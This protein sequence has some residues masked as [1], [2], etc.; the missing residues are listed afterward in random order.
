MEDASAEGPT[1]KYLVNLFLP[2]RLA[3]AGLTVGVTPRDMRIDVLIAMDVISRGDCSISTHGG[4]T[5]LSFRCPP[6]GGIDYE[7]EQIGFGENPQIYAQFG[8][9]PWLLSWL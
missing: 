8:V 2:N 3:L 7:S 6:L 4:R 5:V 1:N 9:N